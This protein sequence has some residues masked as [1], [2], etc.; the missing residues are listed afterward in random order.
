MSAGDDKSKK[1]SQ[2]PIFLIFSFI[3]VVLTII[4]IAAIFVSLFGGLAYYFSDTGN[5]QSRDQL[6]DDI[7]RGTWR[8]SSMPL[9]IVL[10]IYSFLFL[11][12]LNHWK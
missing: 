8:Y 7:L 10:F 11:T 2:Y 9:M 6:V 1:S 3:I 5:H 4:V 12:R